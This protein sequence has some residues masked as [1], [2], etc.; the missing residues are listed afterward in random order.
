MKRAVVSLLVS[1]SFFV[2]V[3][4]SK[5]FASPPLPIIDRINGPSSSFY[6]T[7][8]SPSAVERRRNVQTTVQRRQSGSESSLGA[9]GEQEKV[10]KLLLSLLIDFV[11]FAS[12]GLPGVGEAGDLA[13]APIS[14][15]LISFLYGNALLGGL[16]FLEELLPGADF[17]P[18]ATIGWFIVYYGKSNDLSDSDSSNSQGE[19]IDNDGVSIT[20]TLDAD[21][22]NQAGRLAGDKYGDTGG[23]FMNAIDVDIDI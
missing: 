12:F 19:S 8:F 17:I 15:L 9:S 3:T 14:G 1:I 21:T 6:Q 23:K 11:G 13:W 7:A 10:T 22:S 16:G 5:A 4:P 2:L 20:T 18:T